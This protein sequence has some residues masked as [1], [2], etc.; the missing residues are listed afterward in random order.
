V[1]GGGRLRQKFRIQE[2]KIKTASANI[3][4]QSLRRGRGDTELSPRPGGEI[5]WGRGVYFAGLGAK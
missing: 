3:L 5:D 1:A 4:E 2:K